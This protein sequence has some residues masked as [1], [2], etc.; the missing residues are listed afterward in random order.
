MTG[1]SQ[2]EMLETRTTIRSITKETKMEMSEVDDEGQN[3]DVV[4]NVAVI[5]NNLNKLYFNTVNNTISSETKIN[6]FT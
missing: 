6:I 1:S 2:R 4:L 3:S 5:H